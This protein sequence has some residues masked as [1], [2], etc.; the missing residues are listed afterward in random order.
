MWD[1]VDSGVKTTLGEL[2]LLLL[3][4]KSRC[5]WEAAAGRKPVVPSSTFYQLLTDLC[6][7][8]VL[9]HSLLT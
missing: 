9:L 3:L 7:K 5:Y 2:R 1:P 8:Q 4:F 6:S